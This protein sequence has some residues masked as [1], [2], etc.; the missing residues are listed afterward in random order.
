MYMHKYMIY[1]NISRSNEST[2]GGGG[3][4]ESVVEVDELAVTAPHLKELID[5]KP[6]LTMH[7]DPLWGLEGN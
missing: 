3:G 2:G 1:I 6:T 7:Y 4:G 5:Y